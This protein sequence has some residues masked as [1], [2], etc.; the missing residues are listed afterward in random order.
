MK[1]K[2]I[3]IPLSILLVCTFALCSCSVVTTEMEYK[4][5][6]DI[7]E[8]NVVDSYIVEEIDPST[9]SRLD[10][11]KYIENYCKVI[12]YDNETYKLFAYVFENEQNAADY[13]DL[14]V[15][16]DTNLN[17]KFSGNLFFSNTLRAYSGKNAYIIEGGNR[18]DFADFYNFLSSDFSV[19]FAN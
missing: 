13:C 2:H 10:N 14:E 9:D 6:A 17:Y 3:I 16:T 18:S 7:S 12:L 11:M 5:F 19:S 8:L 15:R 1:K 4:C